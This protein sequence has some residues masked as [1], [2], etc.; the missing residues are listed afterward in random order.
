MA[1]NARSFN[2]GIQRRAE[3]I[4]VAVNEAKKVLATR[5]LEGVVKETPVD[6]GFLRGNWRVRIGAVVPRRTRAGLADKNGRRTITRGKRNIARVRPGQRLTISNA[7]RYAAPIN[8]RNSI[9][10]KAVRAASRGR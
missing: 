10:Q 5:I 4:P 1:S 8:R 6:T 3:R 2:R 7:T 9:V